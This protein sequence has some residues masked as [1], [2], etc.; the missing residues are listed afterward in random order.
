M[1]NK[2]A[3]RATIKDGTYE[4]FGYDKGE[5][6]FLKKLSDPRVSMSDTLDQAEFLVNRVW[7]SHGIYKMFNKVEACVVGMVAY[8]MPYR[9]LP[10]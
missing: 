2:F 10:T 9:K 4:W 1:D 8:P 5:R 7:E 3:I 6:V